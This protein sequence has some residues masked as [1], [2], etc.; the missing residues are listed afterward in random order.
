MDRRPFTTG[1]RTEDRRA[2]ALSPLVER[3]GGTERRE[4]RWRTWT[5]EHQA[6]KDLSERAA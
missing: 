3:R 2:G 1:Q 6:G 5:R 4:P